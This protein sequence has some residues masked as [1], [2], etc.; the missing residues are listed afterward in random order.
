MSGICQSCLKSFDEEGKSVN[1][2]I[3]DEVDHTWQMCPN[4]ADRLREMVL[5][6]MGELPPEI[7]ADEVEKIQATKGHPWMIGPRSEEGKCD[8]CFFIT[9]GVFMSC[10]H[11]N[12]CRENPPSGSHWRTRHDGTG[13]VE[14]EEI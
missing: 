1:F 3:W 11:W 13:W 5:G 6:Y 4:C 14:E 9:P 7:D 8:T 12:E 2:Q 10:A